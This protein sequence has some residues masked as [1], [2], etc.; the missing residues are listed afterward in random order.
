MPPD[1]SE[2]FVRYRTLLYYQYKED[3]CNKINYIN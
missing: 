1:Q 3:K 2:A